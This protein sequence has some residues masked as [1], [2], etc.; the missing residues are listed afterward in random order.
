[1]VW[2]VKLTK[3]EQNIYVH[4]FYVKRRRLNKSQ[5]SWLDEDVGLTQS[6]PRVEGVGLHL[7]F[8]SRERALAPCYS[9]GNGLE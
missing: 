4:F 1:M 6:C 3:V 2:K 8:P 9:E 5:G 7:G